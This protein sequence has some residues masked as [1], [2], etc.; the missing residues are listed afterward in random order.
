M[1]TAQNPYF[2]DGAGGPFRLPPS[3]RRRS[4]IQAATS[5]TFLLALAA[6]EVGPT[7]QP[8]STPLAPFHN[9]AA[10]DARR[11]GP[12][13]QLDT[14]WDGFNDPVLDSLIRRALT[15]NL[16]LAASLARV[17]QAR[18]TAQAAGAQL[19]PT[20]DATGQAAALHQSL[21]SPIGTIAKA[22]PAYNRDQRLYDVG[23]AASWEIDLAGGLRRNEEAAHAEAEAADAELAGTRITVAADVADAYFQIRGNRARIAVVR[24]QIE[25]DAHLLDL[26][27]QLHGRGLANDREVSQAEA[28]LQQAQASLPPLRIALE[29]QLNRLDVLLGAQPGTYAAE[30]S[31]AV[32]IPAIPAIPDADKPTDFLRR[33]P[34]IIAAER[35]VAASNARI[36]VALSDYYP[37][38][39]LSGLLGFES[40]SAN[41]LFTSAAFQPEV[42]GAIRWRIFD[43]GKIDA[44]VQQARGAHA[45]A[46][47]KYRQAVLRAAED[48]E[49]A[50]ITLTQTETRTLQLQ[51]E[52]RSLA[53]SRELS[54]QAY[55]A[56]SIP[57][58]DVL[59]ADRQLLVTRDDLAQNRADAARAAV[60]SFRALGGGW[61]T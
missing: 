24:Q 20:F 48:V 13:P 27:R 6:C 2:A 11:A 53:R 52:V 49:D 46:L 23:A 58:T 56:G 54:Q 39:S 45:E 59:D 42:A 40:L 57:L 16:D 28:V 14:W 9:A 19:L 26:V 51:G 3:R 10:V 31:E 60:R 37:K 4:A 34:D 55:A 15:Q 8:P 5:L 33:R 21:N 61:S 50:F 41:H 36:G 43:F 1:S 22:F 18:A 47:A 38:L 35:Q 7:Y 12:S 44:E 17:Q 32:D 25:V 29:G 30:S